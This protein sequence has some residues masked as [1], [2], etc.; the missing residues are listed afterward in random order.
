MEKWEARCIQPGS[1]QTHQSKGQKRKEREGQRILWPHCQ[2]WFGKSK[3]WSGLSQPLRPFVI[4]RIR[5]SRSGFMKKPDFFLFSIIW[6][7]FPLFG[8]T[9]TNQALSIC[10]INWTFKFIFYCCFAR[11]YVLVLKRIFRLVITKKT[12][13]GWLNPEIDECWIRTFRK[14]YSKVEHTAISDT[15]NWNDRIKWEVD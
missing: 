14:K 4:K 11:S 13:G 7:A 8:L 10:K 9:L 15:E 3:D 1:C 6:S 2:H 12:W 5:M